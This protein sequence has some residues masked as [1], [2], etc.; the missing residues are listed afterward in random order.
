MQIKLATDEDCAILA[1]LHIEGWRAAYKDLLDSSYL[2]GLSIKDRAK[3]WANWLQSPE[4][5]AAI[6]YTG[7]KV[8]AGFVSYGRIRTAPPGQSAIRPLYTGEILALYLLPAH[9]RQGI[10][11]ALMAYA[12]RALKTQKHSSLCLWVLKDNKRACAFYK[13][14]GGQPIGKV[15][16]KIA[17]KSAVESCF[18]WRDTSGLAVGWETKDL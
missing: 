8:P 12:A 14:L 7:D 17:G 16:K 15:K 9:W 11:K 6:A 5:Q 2:D 3:D 10:G 18:G 4:M 13:A 1:Q